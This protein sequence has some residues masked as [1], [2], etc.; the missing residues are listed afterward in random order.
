MEANHSPANK[1]LRRENTIALDVPSD[2]VSCYSG[3]ANE[4]PSKRIEPKVKN[5]LLV[6]SKLGKEGRHKEVNEGHGKPSE[7][8]HK[9]PV[10]NNL[11]CPSM[12]VCTSSLANKSIDSSECAL[13]YRENSNGKG[14][15]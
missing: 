6:D 1:N 4:D 3:E 11:S 9:D 15:N 5:A 13:I 8:H 12:V 7:N 14:G 10:L 2:K